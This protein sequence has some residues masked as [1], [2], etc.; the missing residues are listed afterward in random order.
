MPLL[1]CMN[2][3]HFCRHENCSN[4]W[5]VQ[6][7]PHS[8]QYS[9]LAYRCYPLQRLAQCANLSGVQ[10][11]AACDDRQRNCNMMLQRA[12][13][14]ELHSAAG[15]NTRMHAVLCLPASSSPAQ[16]V[17]LGCWCSCHRNCCNYCI[18][19]QTL[20]LCTAVCHLFWCKHVVHFFLDYEVMTHCCAGCCLPVVCLLAALV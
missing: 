7:L 4:T 9:L 19:L 18:H 5:E 3:Q 10:G 20:A 1:L 12:C 13:C 14:G 11:R 17:P 6:L 2:H 16:P 15:T 8:Q